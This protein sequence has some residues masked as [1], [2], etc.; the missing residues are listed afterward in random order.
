MAYPRVPLELIH[1]PAKR[2]EAPLLT[3]DIQSPYQSMDEMVEKTE[4]YF[5]FG[6]KS[7]WI[8]V[9]SIQAVLVYNQPGHYKFLHNDDLLTDPVIG[10]EL[11]MLAVFD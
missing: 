1:E 10:I 3:I 8:V 6:V 11:P 2:S 7:C 4:R 5:A 9:P